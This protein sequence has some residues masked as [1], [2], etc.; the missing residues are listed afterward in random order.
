MSVGSLRSLDALAHAGY[1]VDAADADLARVAKRYA[2]AITPEMAALIKGT[3][4][5]DPIARQ[6]VPTADELVSRPNE[7]ADPIGDKRHEVVPGLIH[8]YRDRVLIKVTHAC[9]VYCRFCFRREMVGPGGEQALSGAKLEAVLAYIAKKPEIFEAIFTG[10]DPLTLSPRRI[11]LLRDRVAE[12]EHVKVQRWHTRVPVVDPTKIDSAMIKALRHHEKAVYMAIHCNHPRELTP[13]ARDAIR[14][15]V[16]AGIV[17]IS[18]T[19][20]LKGINDNAATLADLMRA[21]VSLRIKPY[22]LHHADLAPG[23][24]HFRTSIA[25]GRAIMQALRGKLSG[26]AQPT[27]VLDIPG[28]IAKVPIG[29]DY[30]GDNVVIDPE[31]NTHPY[32]REELP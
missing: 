11:A 30:L 17:L 32:T 23:T 7:S 2:I 26:I 25:E 21:F 5:D 8:R 31:G 4:A 12:I 10:G 16:D 19:V 20:L 1:I 18:Q 15:L 3:S 29:P 22:Y 24:A 13:A 6:F 9:P 27:Y 14:R 28:G